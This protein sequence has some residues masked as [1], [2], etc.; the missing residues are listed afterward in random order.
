MHLVYMDESGNSGL[1]LADPQQP[2]FVLC[3]MI[4]DEQNWQPLEYDLQ[5][6][7]DARIPSWKTVD[8]FEVHAADLR[9]GSG[10]FAG[11]PVSDRIAFRD[12]WMNVAS[13][14]GVR[15]IYRSVFKKGYAGWLV[16]TFGH[17]VVINPHITAFALLSL[18]VDGYLHSLKGKPRGMFISDENKQVMAD[19]EKSI[20]VLRSE[21]GPMRLGQIIEKGFFIDSSKSHPLQLCDLF[22]LSLRKHVERVR[23]CGPSKT[24]DD[25]GIKLALAIVHKD[26]THDADVLDWLKKQNQPKDGP[27]AIDAVGAKK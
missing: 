20:K 7:L 1:N 14:H 16:N 26:H 15:L 4:V 11:I 9:C 25:S 3:A 19:V 13:K 8:G 6:V 17:G 18:C 5:C 21:V 23:Q 22:A 24:I 12:E 27:P 2:V 10:F